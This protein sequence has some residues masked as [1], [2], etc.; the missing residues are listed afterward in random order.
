MFIVLTNAIG[1]SLIYLLGDTSPADSGPSV[2]GSGRLHDAVLLFINYMGLPWVRAVPAALG[3]L[4]GA[5]VLVPAMAAVRFKGGPRAAW[6]ERMAVSLIVFSLG[7]GVMAGAARTGQIAPNLVPMRYAVF[8]IPLHAGLWILAL[9]YLRK[10]GLRWP[11]RL[12]SGVCV[13]AAI[14][15]LHQGVMSIYA[16]RTADINLQIIADFRGDKRSAAML[17][18][19]YSN[20]DRAQAL[21]ARL[22]GDN[23]FQREWRADPAPRR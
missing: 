12:A 22:R 11:R 18:T 23:F 21:G 7:T 2:G 13:A 9:P 20:L 16:V 14:M 15:L 8:L 19:I 3:W 6:S 1:F 5:T 17:T 10:A 4:I